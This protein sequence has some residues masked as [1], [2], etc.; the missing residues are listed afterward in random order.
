VQ[1]FRFQLN[2]IEN[3]V[4]KLAVGRFAASFEPKLP[5]A[6]LPTA[7]QNTKSPNI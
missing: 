3:L 6:N 2:F 5:T 4:G 7:N 1:I